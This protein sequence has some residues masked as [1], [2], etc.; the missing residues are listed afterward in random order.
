MYSLELGA[1][2]VA[3]LQYRADPLVV[4]AALHD[5]GAALP[6]RPQEQRVL[7]NEY[8]DAVGRDRLFEFGQVL[9]A[10]SRQ[11]HLHVRVCPVGPL[12]AVALPAP[13]KVQR[14]PLGG[15]HAEHA[16]QPFHA[17]V[18]H[19]RVPDKHL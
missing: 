18:Q 14:P 16:Q 2:K 7:G 13:A 11:Y 8:H 9:G 1:G 19:G 10:A 5:H 4:V 15:I 12:H 17:G 6:E 3:G